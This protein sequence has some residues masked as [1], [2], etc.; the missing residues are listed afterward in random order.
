[1][2][3]YINVHGCMDPKRGCPLTSFTCCSV[4]LE[5]CSQTSIVIEDKSSTESNISANT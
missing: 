5:Q 1:M 4:V 3:C 2:M